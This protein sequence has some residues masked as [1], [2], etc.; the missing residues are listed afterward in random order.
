MKTS[1]T[2]HLTY[3]ACAT[4]VILL[5]PLVAM[6]FYRDVNWTLSD[7]IFAAVLLFGAGVV[8]ELESRNMAYRMHRTLFGVAVVTVLLVVWVLAATGD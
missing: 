8:Y 5:I 2:K 4:G 3:F 1:T 7:F 6:Q